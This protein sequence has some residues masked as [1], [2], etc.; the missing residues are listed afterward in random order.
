MY[1]EPKRQKTWLLIKEIGKDVPISSLVSSASIRVLNMGS[2]LAISI[3]LARYMGVE[4]YG[5]YSFVVAAVGWL[6]LCSYLGLP[7]LLTRYLA[8]YDQSGEWRLARGLLIRSWQYIL[9]SSACFMLIGFALTKVE[10]FM[11]GKRAQVLYLALPLIPILALIS[12]NNSALIGLRKILLG[13]LTDTFARTFFFLILLVILIFTGNFSTENVILVQ[14]AATA[15]ALIIGFLG[16]RYFLLKKHPTSTALYRNK[17]WLNSFSS[18]SGVALVSF[19]NVELITLILG[20]TNQN[21]DVA[22][23][24]VAF[25]LALF[26]ALPLTIIE[27]SISPFI[28]RLYHEKKMATLQSLI[29]LISLITFITSFLATLILIIWGETILTIVFGAEYLIAYQPT[30]IIALGY[31]VSSTFGLSM[32]LLYATEYHS[33]TLRISLIGAA[34]TILMSVVLVPLYGAYGAAIT[35]GL[36][37]SVRALLFVNQ[38]RTKLGIKTSFLW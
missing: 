21:S 24:R 12:T 26:V 29:Q 13:T 37:K 33:Q 20:F 30:V 25:S 23:Y 7:M 18:F 4:N 17:E 9:I 28:T 3:V 36:G 38:A 15:V 1:L 32:M 27:S 11:F 2:V 31:L 5:I 22:S 19:F 34:V 16:L 14:I 8:V 10:L 6:A 35:L